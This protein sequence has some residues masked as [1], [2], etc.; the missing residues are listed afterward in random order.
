MMERMWKT[1]AQIGAAAGQESLPPDLLSGIPTGSEL[2]DLLKRLQAEQRR[3]DALN[4]TVGA[5]IALTQRGRYKIRP[6]M[7]RGG[8]GNA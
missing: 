2:A 7:Q 5:A 4:R 8:A 6:K 3:I 1:A